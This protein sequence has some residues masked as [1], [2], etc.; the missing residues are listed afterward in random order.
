[1]PAWSARVANE[2]ALQ[3]EDERG[4]AIQGLGL[5]RDG[6]LMIDGQDGP[7]GYGRS[8]RPGTTLL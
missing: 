8:D 5:Y 7:Q 1:M 6:A 4:P 3:F 2:S